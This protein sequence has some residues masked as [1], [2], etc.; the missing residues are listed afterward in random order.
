MVFAE[1]ISISQT[2]GTGGTEE[3]GEIE[4]TEET[5]ET[6]ENWE[7]VGHCAA[8]AAR[9][10][11]R[12]QEHPFSRLADWQRAPGPGHPRPTKS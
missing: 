4:E 11:Y 5:E 3:T 1:A 8:A 2:G 6:E 10:P 12:D 7:V 9:H